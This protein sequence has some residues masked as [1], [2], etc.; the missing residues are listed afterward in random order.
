MSS[1]SFEEI[2]RT[3]DRAG[4]IKEGILMD[5]RDVHVLQ[6][7]QRRA[8]IVT[9]SSQ[10]DA[11]KLAKAGFELGTVDRLR[12]E[13]IVK[14]TVDKFIK[15]LSGLTVEN[16]EVHFMSLEDVFMQYYREEK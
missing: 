6:E 9:V 10:D 2:D 16:L 3:C 8:F 4:I 11:D 12:I 15:F 1:H 13:V 7:Q 5:I 14:G